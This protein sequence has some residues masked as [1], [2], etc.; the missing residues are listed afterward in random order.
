MANTEFRKNYLM[1]FNH[2]NKDQ[3]G[4]MEIYGTRSNDEISRI[5]KDIFGESESESEE[6]EEQEEIE[7]DFTE[8]EY[9][10]DNK[11]G[12]EIGND[13]MR[14][15]RQHSYPYG[16]GSPPLPTFSQEVGI[17]SQ[18]GNN[19]FTFEQFINN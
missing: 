15:H 2:F 7:S 8:N 4:G 6:D 11:D 16:F 3:E 9:P 14:I 10:E 18:T 17:T 1:N 13:E 5:T 19:I 12:L